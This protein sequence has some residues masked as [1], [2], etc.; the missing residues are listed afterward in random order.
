MCTAT[1]AP[2]ATSIDTVET[3]RCS[4]IS[5]DGPIH[6]TIGNS[7]SENDNHEAGAWSS[8]YSNSEDE[9][10]NLEDSIT[11]VSIGLFKD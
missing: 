2:R 11:P 5:D 10:T 6:T 3:N 8:D 4:N 7:S 9:F 1:I